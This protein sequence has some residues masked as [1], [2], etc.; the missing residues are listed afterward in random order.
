LIFKTKRTNIDHQD[1]QNEQD[2]IRKSS[3]Y[4]QMLSG[5]CQSQSHTK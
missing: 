4:H 3:A 5:K 2:I 1:K